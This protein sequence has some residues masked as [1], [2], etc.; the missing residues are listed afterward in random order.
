MSI[1]SEQPPQDSHDDPLLRVFELLYAKKAV[2]RTSTLTTD[3]LKERDEALLLHLSSLLKEP[4]QALINLGDRKTNEQRYLEHGYFL[5]DLDGAIKSFS[6]SIP[7]TLGYPTIRLA[8]RQFC[9]LLAEKSSDTWNGLLAGL[10][11]RICFHT[12]IAVTLRSIDQQP[13]QALCT[14]SKLLNSQQLQV[15]CLFVK[16]QPSVDGAHLLHP[17][18]LRNDAALLQRL[19][20]LVLQHLDRPLPSI[21]QL[22]KHLGTNTFT[23]KNGFKH[24]FN[25]GIYQFYTQERLAKAKVMLLE[26]DFSLSTIAESCG[27]GSTATF[28]KAFKKKYGTTP[29]PFKKARLFL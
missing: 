5:L 29:L 6:I 9:S 7:Y 15:S 24:Y 17:K 16:Q 27:F 19:H 2:R 18:N 20:D 22:A 26:T 3:E 14:V 28:S 10:K 21:A 8:E 1:L 4:D 11:G 23:L 12:V 25:M 13:V